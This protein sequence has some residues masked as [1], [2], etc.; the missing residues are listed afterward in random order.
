VAK[1]QAQ[2]LKTSKA[3]KTKNKGAVKTPSVT[4]SMKENQAPVSTKV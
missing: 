4:Q 3:A 1:D 2:R